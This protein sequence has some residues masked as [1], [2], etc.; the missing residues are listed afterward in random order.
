[1][2]KL[3]I[4]IDNKQIRVLA[5]PMVMWHFPTIQNLENQ[6]LKC[7]AESVLIKQSFFD[8]K[9]S[10]DN[11]CRYQLIIENSN[12]HLEKFIDREPIFSNSKFNDHYISIL[13]E[14]PSIGIILESPH[15][16]EFTDEFQPISPAQGETGKNIEAFLLPLIKLINAQHY[17]F[18]KSRYRILILNPIPF[19]TSLYYF[20]KQP[21]RKN[22]KNSGFETLRNDVWQTLWFNKTSIKINFI[23]NIKTNKI[24]LILNCCTANLFEYVNDSLVGLKIPIINCYHPSRWDKLEIIQIIKT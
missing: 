21:L 5:L 4:E 18:K 15:I 12:Y 7:T 10:V 3:F 1:M 19:Q 24:D 6:Y 8:N 11:V 9:Q 23:V 20:H 22:N 13:D 17:A 16:K 14:L 2:K